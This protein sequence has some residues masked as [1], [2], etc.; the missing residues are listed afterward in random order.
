MKTHITV[1][2]RVYVALCHARVTATRSAV[3]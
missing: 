1:V 3:L 2:V